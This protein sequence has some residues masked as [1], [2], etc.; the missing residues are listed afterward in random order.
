M[1]CSDCFAKTTLRKL[2]SYLKK[3]H[4]I[5]CCYSTVLAHLGTHWVETGGYYLLSFFNDSHRS[6][7]N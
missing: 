2:T 7:L 6:E 4:N 5:I 3:G 1:F